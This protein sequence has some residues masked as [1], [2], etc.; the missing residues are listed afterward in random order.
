M[1]DASLVAKG[2]QPTIRLER[3]LADPPEVV[4]R[5]IT[6]PDELAR[7]FPCAVLVDGGEWKVGAT[8][9]FPFPAD[10][11]DMTLRGEVLVFEPPS[12]LSYTWGD[13]TLRFELSASGGGTTLVL[14]NTLAADGAARNAAGW[15][16]CLDRLCGVD[17]AAGA[18]RTRFESYAASFA[19]TLGPQAG[20][21][22]GY[23]GK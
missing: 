20:P 12:V 18:W 13:D 8:I 10:V 23:K 5:A 19:P 16:E 1:T 21:P 4:W 11:I 22:D 17:V 7:W 6:E 3:E 14:L 2:S 15:D 9:E